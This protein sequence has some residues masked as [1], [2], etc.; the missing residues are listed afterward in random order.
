MQS[1]ESSS[2]PDAEHPHDTSDTSSH[3]SGL[4]SGVRYWTK[5]EQEEHR[6]EQK[7]M[8]EE[9]RILMKSWK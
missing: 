7:K 3:A 4:G 8:D 2:H 1:K 5:Q 9:G 6:A